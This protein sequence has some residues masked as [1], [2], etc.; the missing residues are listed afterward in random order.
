[1]KRST[2]IGLAE[3]AEV[4]SERLRLRDT[5]LGWPREH[6]PA[7]GIDCLEFRANS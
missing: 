7:C 3:T 1:V 2:A 5:D 4:A 6:F